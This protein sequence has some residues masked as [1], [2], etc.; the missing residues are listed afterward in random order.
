MAS[1]LIQQWRRAAGLNRN[2]K[3]FLAMAAINGFG[4]SIVWLFLNLFIL[5][6]GN[7]KSLAKICRRHNDCHDRPAIKSPGYEAAGDK[8]P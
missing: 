6:R 8:S 2:M 4:N 1:S 7:D 3:L 5:A